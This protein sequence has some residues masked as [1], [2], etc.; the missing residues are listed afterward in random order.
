MTKTLAC[1]QE[2]TQLAALNPA[3]LARM[4]PTH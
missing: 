2:A 3:A 4:R 1:E